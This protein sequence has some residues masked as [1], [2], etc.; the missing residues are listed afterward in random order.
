MARVIKADSMRLA[1]GAAT[2]RLADFHRQAEAI[3][4]QARDRARRIVA[5]AQ[6]EALRLRKEATEQANAEGLTGEQ[7]EPSAKKPD[8]GSVASAS[9]LAE[10]AAEALALVK[11]IVAELMCLRNELAECAG[12]EMLQ[13]ALQIAEKIVGQ[14]AETNISAAQANLHKALELY[15]WG[16]IT[17]HVNPSE[18]DS[19]RRHCAELTGV[20]ASSGHIEL[21]ADDQIARG[22]AKAITG[23]G[24][25]D[26]T[27]QTQLANVVASLLGPQEPEEPGRYFS[28]VGA[29]ER[30]APDL[31]HDPPTDLLGADAGSQAP[32]ET[33][34]PST[35]TGRKRRQSRSSHESV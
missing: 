30:A 34:Q 7:Q 5:E 22:G 14:I 33:E 17:V 16:D 6:A 29:G 2:L 20:L 24:C 21:V 28:D 12:R 11:E 4:R 8:R 10:D 13:F 1:G 25:V 19:L 18:L 15:S 35:R 31:Q 32:E 23:G 9:R 26:A 3:V 27:I